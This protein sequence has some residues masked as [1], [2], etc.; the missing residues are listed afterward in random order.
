MDKLNC[1]RPDISPRASGHIV[2]QIEMVKTSVGKGFAYE[3]N[4]SVYFD[5]SKF[6]DYGKLSGRNVEDMQA[7]AR[8]EVSPDKK[9]PADFALWK[10]AEAESYY[11]VAKPVGTGFSRL[12]SR[13]LGDEHKIS[14]PAFRYSRRRTRKPVPASRMRNR[15]GRSSSRQI[16]L[17]DTGCIIIW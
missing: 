7:G 11:A 6:P 1:L 9:H 4:G 16:P 5:V 14:G 2:E 12:A 15:T 10:K 17:S 13:M 3:V 8:V